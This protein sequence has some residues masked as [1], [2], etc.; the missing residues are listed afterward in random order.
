MPAY[1][2]ESRTLKVLGL[3]MAVAGIAGASVAAEHMRE[4]W[5]LEV[6]HL[7]VLLALAL[8]AANVCAVGVM[9]LAVGCGSVRALQD[10]RRRRAA[11]LQMLLANLLL[12]VLIFGVLIDEQSATRSDADHA[13]TWVLALVAYG[14]CLLAWRLWRRSRRQ[15]AISADEAMAL[16]PRPP[17][18]YLR[19]FRDDG[20]SLLAQD[21]STLKRRA[22]GLLGLPTP[23]EHMAKILA[24]IG[25]LIAIGKPG[26]PL[27]ELGAARLY[28]AHDQWQQT[29]TDLM[30]RAALVVV[31]VGASPGVLWEIEQALAQLPRH[32][33]VLAVLG[34]DPVAPELVA[35]LAPVLGAALEQTLWQAP[36]RHRGGWRAMLLGHKVRRIGGMVC[37]DAEGRA[38]AVPV[39]QETRPLRG[40]NPLRL[41]RPSAA[42]LEEAWKKV[43]EHANPAW[44]EGTVQRSRMMAVG[45]ALMFGL[46]GAHWF[47]LGN[48]RR[49]WIYIAMLPLALAPLFL[50]YAD[51]L[52]FIWIDRAEFDL[53]MVTARR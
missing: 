49:G 25:P 11:A 40:L 29:V 17:S 28:V 37:F 1:R 10:P 32:R 48:H 8:L 24:R 6:S 7:A 41:M 5:P 23:E 35:R 30:Q 50:S 53:R 13:L 45:L 31:R 3:V 27:P 18:L 51:A 4:N 12:P 14:I 20:V 34:G 36:D 9:L 46:V 21:G 52:R 42:P 15:E 43:F 44:G 2:A 39:Q 33:L 47:Y 22:V 16:D 19:S 26:E 38:R